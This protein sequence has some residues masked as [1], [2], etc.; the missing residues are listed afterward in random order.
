MA[1]LDIIITHWKEKWAEGRKQFEM[2]RMQRGAPEDEWNVILVQ[3]GADEENTLK[4]HLKEYPFIRDIIQIPASGV[5]AAR[6]AGLDASNAE[7]VMFCDFDDC[8]Y[9]IDSLHRILESIREAGDRADLLWSD[10][11]IEMR[12]ADGRFLKVKK[13]W[14]SVFNHGK[15]YRRQLLTEHGIRFDEELDYSEDALFNATV[16]MTVETGRSA[17]MPETVYMWCYRDGSLSNYAG[18]DPKRNL[19]AYKAR[20]Q[21]SEEYA[22]HG[23]EYNARTAALRW[24]LNYYW[25]INGARPLD[26]G[27][28]EEWVDRVRLLVQRWPGAV[29][30]TTKEDRKKLFQVAMKEAQQKG[31]IRKDMMPLTEWIKEIGAL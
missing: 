27:T 1:Q 14:N 3:D 18:G 10:I 21:I 31:L 2:L 30:G 11:W 8:L 20:L 12:A 9:S 25:E 22:K 7:W 26:G 6:N 24:M 13:G 23:S 16:S 29:I 19:C 5:S 17:R 28:R 4:T 15:V